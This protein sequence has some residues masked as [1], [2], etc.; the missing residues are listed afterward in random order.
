VTKNDAEDGPS[1]AV[2]KPAAAAP[3]VTPEP[4]AATAPATPTTPTEEL[5]ITEE[6]V[7]EIED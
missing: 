4:P 6:I 1:E 5:M 7:I 3:V 2:E